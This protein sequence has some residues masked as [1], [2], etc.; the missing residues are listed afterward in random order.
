MSNI[1]LISTINLP[2]TY[3]NEIIKV[4]LKEFDTKMEYNFFDDNS[5]KISKKTAITVAVITDKKYRDI[6]GANFYLNLTEYDELD[7]KEYRSLINTEI[8][9][10]FDFGSCEN[11]ENSEK[12]ENSKNVS[13]KNLFICIILTISRFLKYTPILMAGP[14]IKNNKTSEK[15][16]LKSLI[17]VRNYPNNFEF[18]VNF[19][20]KVDVCSQ[21]KYFSLEKEPHMSFEIKESIYSSKLKRILSKK[22]AKNYLAFQNRANQFY[23]HYFEDKLYFSAPYESFNLMSRHMLNIP[24]LEALNTNLLK[25][26]IDK[27]FVESLI[28]SFCENIYTT[29]H[30]T[31]FSEFIIENKKCAT[32]LELKS[33]IFKCMFPILNVFFDDY[34][35]GFKRQLF[36]F[37]KKTNT[38]TNTNTK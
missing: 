11:Y 20:L 12:F 31:M 10:N 17:F 21:K 18:D 4:I 8:E 5:A 1:N 25:S 28:V 3:T 2:N 36:I 23:I 16:L 22:D 32:D 19:Q 24:A 7:L 6:I 33:K 29:Y 13:A 35:E 27:K 15:F 38:N 37:N 30:G 34:R 14:K 9:D 26:N